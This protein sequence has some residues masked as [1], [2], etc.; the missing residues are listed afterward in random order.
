MIT[1]AE[2]KQLVET[3]AKNVERLLA[4]IEPKIREAA[5]KGERSVFIYEQELW[6]AEEYK[7]QPTPLQQRVM[8]EL[9]KYPRSFGVRFT[10]DD[11][12]YVPRGLQDDDGNGPVHTN[13]GIKIS[14]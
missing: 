11:H 12:T 7:P 10:S 4:A 8:A 1:A 2:A 6:S 13:W 14:W 3:S 9:E 5:E